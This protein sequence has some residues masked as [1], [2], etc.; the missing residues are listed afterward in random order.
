MFKKIFGVLQK[1]GK[2]LMLPVAI[3]PAAGLLLAFGNAL[4]NPVLTNIAPFLEAGWVES[5][6]SI[7]EESGDIIFGNLPILFAVGVAL[8][9]AGGEGV[10]ALAALVG[11]L[12]MNATMGTAL[13]LTP[14]GVLEAGD[15]AYA[16]LLGVPSLQSGVFG[17]IIVGVLA[18]AMY[19]RFFNIELPSYL[20]FFA[21]KRFV[22]IATAAS[23]V[24]L[25]LL[26]VFIW[27]PIQ[28][29][30]NTFS[31]FVLN[32]NT[33]LSAFVF[34]VIERSLIPFGLHHIFY[35]PFWFEFGSYVNQAGEVIR[36][37]N[38]IFQAQIKDGLQELT[39][40]TFMTGK[41]PFMMFGLPAAAL[42]IYH[43]ADPRRKK[44]V[45]GIMGSAALTSFLTGITEPIEFSFLF[46][47]PVLF[48]IHAIFAGLSFMTMHLLDV[49]IGMTFSGGLIDYVLFGAIN[50]QTN[51]WLVIPVG[52]VFALIYYFGFR[53]AIRKF[54]LMTPGREKDEDI[55]ELEMGSKNASDLASNILEAMGGQQNIVDLDACI[56]RLRVSV[57]DSGQVDKKELKK[58]GAAGVLEVGNNIQAI[59]G[60]R[61]EIIKGQMQDVMS[62]KRPRAEEV[63][64][65]VEVVAATGQADDFISPIAG[66]LKPLSEVPDQVFAGKMMGDGFAI[67]PSDGLVVSPV[68]GTIVTLFPTKHA[69]G[70]Q[71]D[72]GR[73]IL[74][75]VGIDTVKLAGEGFEA[76][77]AQGD[78]VE[79]GQPLLK[80]DIDYIQEHATS[81]I[82]PIIFTNLFEG[83]SVVLN[84]SG[85]VELKEEN[86]VTIE[87]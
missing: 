73:E 76:L 58:L 20:G 38:P 5:I 29:G 42:A 40:G 85:H 86:I 82:T 59:F 47:A 35:T 3:L 77:V 75:H 84:K 70:I 18:A 12:I 54:N 65:P 56:T 14:M 49:K 10:A 71:S 37:D 16:L 13:G 79:K 36:G 28:E 2:A 81:I 72:S 55:E 80:V 61:S 66:E 67:V 48:G 1:I 27:P 43:E 62:G 39:A 4:Q 50:P 46:V 23:A 57:K 9:L 25:G 32:W 15:P 6:A 21:G 69:L 44:I 26:M 8:G 41:Y 22:P 60:P 74:I 87:K 24:V 19:N 52:L 64:Q 51:A 34:G 63:K 53:F 30:M 83:E 11:Y 7:M 33:T 45:A 31:N 78:R 68:D 17:G